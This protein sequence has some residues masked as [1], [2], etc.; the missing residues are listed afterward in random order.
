MA[1]K[2]D[3]SNP[4]YL[5]IRLSGKLTAEDYE[6]FVPKVESIVQDKGSIRILMTMI[7]FHGWEM[8]AAWEDT[9]FGMRHFHDIERL[10]MIGEKAWQHGMSVFCKPFTKAKIRY[11]DSSEAA[12]AERWIAD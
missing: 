11:F 9:K 3:D 6:D 12:E 5:A 2:I 7:D 10:A 4:D 8:A 1:I